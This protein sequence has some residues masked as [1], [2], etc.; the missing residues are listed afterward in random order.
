M[1]IKISKKPVSYNKAMKFLNDRV[2]DI[3]SDKNDELI[4]I[5]EHPNLYTAGISAT[6]N[7]LLDKNKFPTFKTNRGGKWTF[8]GK[9]Q[10]IVYFILDLNKRGKAIRAL[11]NKIQDIIILS[12]KEIGIEAHKDK[13]NIGI[14][15]NTNGEEAKIAAIGIKVKK[16]IAYHGFSLNVNV[17]KK[18]YK[19]I[20]PCGIKNKGIA[21]ISDFKKNIHNEKLNK[22]LIKNFLDQLQN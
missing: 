9:G 20:I 14:W 18:N 1:E 12:L 21:N 16:W 4:W 6:D 2:N 13:N 5:L 8:H 17:N 10:K 3:H 11:V 22:I 15:V 7:D 19:G